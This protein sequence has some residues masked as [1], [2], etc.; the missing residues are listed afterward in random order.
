MTTFFLSPFSGTALTVLVLGMPQRGTLRGGDHAWYMY[1]YTYINICK[2]LYTLC[3]CLFMNTCLCSPFQWLCSHRARSGHA[4]TWH[5]PRW[6]PRVV[7][8]NFYRPRQ[9]Q[10]HAAFGRPGSL[11]FVESR[12]PRR[13]PVGL[14]RTDVWRA[15]VCFIHW[16][17]WGTALL[18]TY[19]IYAYLSM[20][21]YIYIYV[22]I[23]IYTGGTVQNRCL[24]RRRAFLQ[25]KSLGWVTY[26]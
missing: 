10:P 19:N 24:A 3:T 7:L 11:R 17:A 18:D 14:F 8:F 2:L 6:R 23:Y 25:S 26:I 12:L 16:G 15:D 13:G 22:C 20:S 21:S 5:T 1:M 9:P 4:A